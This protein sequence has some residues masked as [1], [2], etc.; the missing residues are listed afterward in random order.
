MSMNELLIEDNKCYKIYDGLKRLQL[1]KVYY[2]C[3][4]NEFK[5][6]NMVLEVELNRFSVVL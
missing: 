4:L 1:N 3:R 2:G 5:R 6:H